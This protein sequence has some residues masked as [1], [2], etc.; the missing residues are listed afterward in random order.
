MDQI[1]YEFD[2][3]KFSDRD[4]I[5]N[6]F[7]KMYEKNAKEVFEANPSLFNKMK[8]FDGYPIETWRDFKRYISDERFVFDNQLFN[9]VKA[10]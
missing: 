4:K 9:F 3:L 2:N 8:D 5:V 6:Q 1:V 7:R 10:K